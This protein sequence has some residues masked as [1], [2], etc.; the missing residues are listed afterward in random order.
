MPLI[1]FKIARIIWLFICG[2]LPNPNWL[3]FFGCFRAKK[4]WSKLLVLRNNNFALDLPTARC[5]EYSHHKNETFFWNANI[6]LKCNLWFSQVNLAKIASISDA[7][8]LTFFSLLTSIGVYFLYFLYFPA[9]IQWVLVKNRC[10][11]ANLFKY[12]FL[13]SINFDIKKI[14]WFQHSENLILLNVKHEIVAN[15]ITN[16]S[17]TALGPLQSVVYYIHWFSRT[18]DV[19]IQKSSNETV[20]EVKEQTGMNKNAT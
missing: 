10:F 18:E 6:N 16:K 3:T 12:S 19:L 1:G 4:S 20:N 5:D 7:N 8:R 15:F 11:H 14:V 13:C 9:L 17:V 2:V